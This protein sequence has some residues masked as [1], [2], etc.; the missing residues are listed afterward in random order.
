MFNQV[1]DAFNSWLADSSR[2]VSSSQSEAASALTSVVSQLQSAVGCVQTDLA[3]TSRSLSR[4]ASSTAHRVAVAEGSSGGVGVLS[5]AQLEAGTRAVAP[6]VQ[7]PRVEIQGLLS[8]RKYDEALVKTLNTASLDILLWACKQVRGSCC[9]P[10]P[11]DQQP[12]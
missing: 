4:L 10:S 11:L 2:L 1:Q 3:D 5:V 6:V 7:D 12:W 9:M 8:A